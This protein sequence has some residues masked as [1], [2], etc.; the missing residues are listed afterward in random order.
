MCV[1]DDL[2]SSL[3]EQLRGE[4]KLH[5]NDKRKLTSIVAAAAASSAVRDP[6]ADF[7]VEY[8]GLGKAKRLTSKS[9]FAIAIRRNIGN[10]SAK[11]CLVEGSLLDRLRRWTHPTSAAGLGSTKGRPPHST[12]DRLTSFFL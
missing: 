10:A 5:N 8:R 1:K 12:L 6:N 2:I 7:I 4:R 3:R 11:D 9:G